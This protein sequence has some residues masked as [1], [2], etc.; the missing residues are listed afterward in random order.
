[1]WGKF[2]LQKK[3]KGMV[4]RNQSYKKKSRTGK[5][6]LVVRDREKLTGSG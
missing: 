6:I 5:V 1:M 2:A 4:E 3:K